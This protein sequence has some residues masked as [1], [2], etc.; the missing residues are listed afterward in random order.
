MT[1]IHATYLIGAAAFLL[2]AAEAYILGLG[3][4]PAAAPAP[5]RSQE[6]PLRRAE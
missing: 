5:A 2:F 4:R 1:P 6:V 3:Q